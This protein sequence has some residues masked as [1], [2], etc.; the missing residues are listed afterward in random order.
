MQGDPGPQGPQGIQGLT[1]ATGPQ[2]LPGVKGDTGATG[3]Q[4]AQGLQGIP[5]TP[6]SLDAWSRLGNGGTNAA[7]NFLGTTDNADLVVKTNNSEKIRLL[8]NGNFGVG[9]KSPITKFSVHDITAKA[10]IYSFNTIKKGGSLDLGLAR[11]LELSPSAVQADDLLGTINFSGYN[12]VSFNSSASIVARAS[13]NYNSTAGGSYLEFKTTREDSALSLTRMIIDNNGRVGIGKSP[14]Q[15]LDVNGTINVSGG[16][17]N[18]VN[19]SNSSNADLLALAYGSVDLNGNIL[20]SNSG[21]FILFKIGVGVY[22]IDFT[23]GFNSI[24][25]T[26]IATLATGPGEIAAT[27]SIS[28]SSPGKFKV[29]TYN[30]AGSPAD[31]D[32]NFVVYK[33]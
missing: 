2:G 30:S 1:G 12:G 29:R 15:T 31:R 26:T 11:G 23:D 28:G 33:P 7:I 27:N 5:G 24:N 19:R 8:A 14:I 21:N 32:F 25:F 16:F 6:G 13:Q 9:T 3:P 17:A 22:E 20:T 4:G 18:E 10:N